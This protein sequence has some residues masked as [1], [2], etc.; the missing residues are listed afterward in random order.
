MIEELLSHVLLVNTVIRF[1]SHTQSNRTGGLLP[2]AWMPKTKHTLA[3]RINLYFYL[4]ILHVRRISRV[5]FVFILNRSVSASFSVPPTSHPFAHCLS[6]YKHTLLCLAHSS[7]LLQAFS[8]PIHRCVINVTHV[9]IDF[10]C[11][12]NEFEFL[13]LFQFFFSAVA[14][15]KI[16]EKKKEW[17]K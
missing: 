16:K 2:S 6:F 3:F 12:R 14:S 1:V 5:I 17:K 7:Y 13:F 10:M 8:L 9:V 11:E 15:Q 4:Q